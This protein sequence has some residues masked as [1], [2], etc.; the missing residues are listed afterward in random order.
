VR[1]LELAAN[2]G[3]WHPASNPFAYWGF[4]ADGAI[5]G[6]SSH[7]T[8]DLFVKSGGEHRLE[9]PIRVVDRIDLRNVILT[10]VGSSQLRS[11]RFVRPIAVH[12]VRSMFRRT[13]LDAARSAAA[14]L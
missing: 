14:C 2:D 7:C 8:V 5:N 3:A 4:V 11:I 1:L 9:V 10:Y 12:P 6:A 13:S